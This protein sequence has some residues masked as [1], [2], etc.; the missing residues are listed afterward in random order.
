[1]SLIHVIYLWL[2]LK[3]YRLGNYW[4]LHLSLNILLLLLLLMMI[5]LH[6]IVRL[7]LVVLWLWASRWW[8][9]RLFDLNLNPCL[10]Q[11]IVISGVNVSIHL[12]LIRLLLLLFVLLLLRVMRHKV[13]YHWSWN[14]KYFWLR[15]LMKRTKYELISKHWLWLKIFTHRFWMHKL[16]LIVIDITLLKLLQRCKIIIRLSWF[17]LSQV[18]IHH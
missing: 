4:L 12:L 11:S 9:C 7:L 18:R 1:M 3:K 16:S 10:L 14:G 8:S 15:L 5:L 6:L 17:F 2:L 13:W